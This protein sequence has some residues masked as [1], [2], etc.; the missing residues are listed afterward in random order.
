MQI[1]TTGSRL[2][3]I[4]KEQVITEQETKK[5]TLEE[6]DGNTNK[7]QREE[8]TDKG[9]F[10]LCLFMSMMFVNLLTLEFLQLL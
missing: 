6:G 10:L 1:Q 8:N 9:E 2:L 5:R 3:A 4:N 7:G